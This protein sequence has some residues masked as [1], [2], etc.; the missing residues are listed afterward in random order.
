R[1]KLAGVEVI[2]WHLPFDWTVAPGSGRGEINLR[3]SSLHVAQGRATG[4]A[5]FAFGEANRLEGQITF[6]GLDLGPLLRESRAVSQTGTG[7]LAGRFEFGSSDFRGLGDLNGT[8]DATLTQTQT[9]DI[10]LLGQLT[11]YLKSG[12]TAASTFNSGSLRAILSRGIIR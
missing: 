8:L 10:P 12:L 4:R 6:L 3:E 7:R 1:G 2:D 11:P 5:T 9:E